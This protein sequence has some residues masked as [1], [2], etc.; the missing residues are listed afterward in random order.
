MAETPILYMLEWVVRIDA[1]MTDLDWPPELERT[2]AA[3]RSHTTK[4]NVTIT[5]A[6]DDLGTQMD[7]LGVD[8]WR[9]STSMDH[10]S[11]DP[12]YPYSS[13]PEPDD[14][15]V[16]VRWRKDGEQFAIGADQYDRVRDNVREI[17]LYVAEKRKMETRPITTGRSEFASARLPPGDEERQSIVVADQPPHDVLGVS[18]DAPESVVRAAARQ[19]KK[20]HHPD[21]GGDESEFKRIVNAE[22]E[23]TAT[24]Q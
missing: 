22:K 14:P 1:H 13:Q 2:P 19:L 21:A 20:E 7:R 3:D 23:L 24:D 16:V 12:N 4:F 17:G 10:Q 9:L 18:P 15:G 11:Q 8:D 6:I 5:R